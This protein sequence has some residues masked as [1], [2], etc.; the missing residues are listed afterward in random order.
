[1]YSRLPLSEHFTLRLQAAY[2]YHTAGKEQISQETQLKWSDTE[3]GMS[4]GFNAGRWEVFAGA[5]YF[6]IDGD[7]ASTG[8][9]AQTRTFSEEGDTNRYAGIRLP[10]DATGSMEIQLGSGA[11]DMN[12]LVFS[13]QF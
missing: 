3:M 4:L 9:V 1:M 6:I 12:R 7:E 2:I 10:V 5:A 13:R 11:K 8:T